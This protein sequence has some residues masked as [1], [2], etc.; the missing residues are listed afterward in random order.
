[1]AI[2]KGNNYT[3]MK[4]G[5][6]TDPYK[7]TRDFYP[8]DMVVLNHLF[9]A[10]REVAESFGYLEYGAS[11][12]EPAELYQAKTGEEI[13]NEQTYTFTDRGGREVTLRPEMT[14]TVARMVAARKRELAFPLRWYSIPNL[15][16]YEQP[17]RGRLREHYQL[18]VDIFGV[19]TVEAEIEVIALGANILRKLGAT[20]ADFE[21]LVN[22]RKIFRAITD[23][24]E[25]SPVQTHDL[26]KLIDKK[27]KLSHKEFSEKLTGILGSKAEPIERLLSAEDLEEFLK[28]LP[29]AIRNHEGVS[30]IETVLLGLRALGFTNIRFSPTLMRGFDYYTG[31]VFEMFD[32]NHLN[33]RSIFGGGRYDDLLGIFGGDKL[34]AVGFGMGDVTLQ[35]FL[36]LHKLLPNYQSTVELYL[37]K[38]PDASIDAVNALAQE[39]RTSGVRVAVDY[40]DRKLGDQIKSAD[41]QKIP[42]LAVIGKNEETSGVYKVKNLA[43]GEERELSLPD[44]ADF[45]K[46]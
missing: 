36:V 18:N 3:F 21:I 2:L 40:T 44:I 42:Y 7:G 37:A 23:T 29:D 28:L 32:T 41:K 16:R 27:D 13:V 14:P 30:E 26:S 22:N 46:Q 9:K 19:A 4:D 17:Q 25:L 33:R 31:I 15:F 38:A 35:D 6:S 10:M 24:L 5:L 45:V 20:D 11:I 8:E 34:P 12:L 43:T 1:M 39:L